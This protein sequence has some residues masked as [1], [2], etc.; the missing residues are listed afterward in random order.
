MNP[1]RWAVS[2]WDDTTTMPNELVTSLG[3]NNYG[4]TWL[5]V[6]DTWYHVA[7]TRASGTL[8]HFIDG[9]QVGSNITA[10]DNVSTSDTLYVGSNQSPGDYW[11]GYLD[12]LRIS[13]GI[14]R[15]TSNFTPPSTQYGNPQ[16]LLSGSVDISGQPSGTDM[17]Y[18]VE[19][20]NNK[21]LRL[22]GASLLWA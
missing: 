5:P 21:N 10:T 20:L 15:W 7:I 8:R 18:K 16:R 17:K 14:A 4:T 1:S 2:W 19:T 12:E 13:K 22:H 3:G 11:D 6:V 9:T